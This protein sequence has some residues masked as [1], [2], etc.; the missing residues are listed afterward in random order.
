MQQFLAFLCHARDTQ[1]F[2][3][4]SSKELPKHLLVPDRCL[5]LCSMHGRA[6]TSFAC[7]DSAHNDSQ[8]KKNATV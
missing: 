8:H 3:D 4:A 6:L 5:F 2:G 1:W 7:S